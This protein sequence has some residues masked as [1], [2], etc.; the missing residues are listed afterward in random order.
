MIFQ[1]VKQFLVN[2]QTK[3]NLCKIYSVL[4]FDAHES[5]IKSILY[6]CVKGN[7]VLGPI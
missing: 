2:L 4:N 1:N 3:F 5:C 7:A 6:I